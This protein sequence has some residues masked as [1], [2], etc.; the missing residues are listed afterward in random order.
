LVSLVERAFFG[1]YF[2]RDAGQSRHGPLQRWRPAKRV[3]C[4]S[5]LGRI[6]KSA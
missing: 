4:A 3:I 2:I 6:V 5:W 1:G